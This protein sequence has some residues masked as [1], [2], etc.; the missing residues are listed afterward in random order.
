MLS[1]VEDLDFT[2]RLMLSEV[3]DLEIPERASFSEVEDLEIAERARFSEADDLEFRGNTGIAAQ[4]TLAGGLA[5]DRGV[6]LH[7]A[8][9][10]GGQSWG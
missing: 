4:R 9:R 5:G 6:P 10:R 8:P 2:A 7:S 1:E 3:E